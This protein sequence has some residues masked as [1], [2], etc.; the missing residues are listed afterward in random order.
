MKPGESIAQAVSV[1][2]EPGAEFEAKLTF[3]AKDGADEIIDSERQEA[4][5]AFEVE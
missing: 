3:T 1:E 2:Y 5:F 4:I